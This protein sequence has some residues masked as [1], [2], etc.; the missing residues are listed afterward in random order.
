MDSLHENHTYELTEL[1]KGKKAIM[2]KWVHKLKPGENRN[3]PRYK[4]CI[5]LKGFQQKKGVDFDKIFSPVVKMA[6]IRTVL[7]IA[8]SMNMEIE[9]LDVKT[10]F[11]HGEL[12]E[13]ICRK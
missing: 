7:S 13:R 11:L 12:E 4:S 5:V 3:P 2:N 6:S 1:P 8:A 10:T 9:Q